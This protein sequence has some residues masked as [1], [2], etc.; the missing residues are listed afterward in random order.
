M[1]LPDHEWEPSDK[2]EAGAEQEMKVDSET[3]DKKE[4][5]K[6]EPV[7]VQIRRMSQSHQPNKKEKFDGGG[8]YTN[9]EKTVQQYFGYYSKLVNQQNML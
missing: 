4:E 3:A 5:T 7:L 1:N 8:V 9:E 6:D 2:W